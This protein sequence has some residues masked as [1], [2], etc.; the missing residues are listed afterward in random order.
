MVENSSNYHKA[1]VPVSHDL[2][3]ESVE[4]LQRSHSNHNKKL[5]FLKY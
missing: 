4:D 2:Q 3:G 1:G 5:K